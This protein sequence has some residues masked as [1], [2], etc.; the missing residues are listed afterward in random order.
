[1]WSVATIIT[2]LYSFMLESNPTLGSVETTPLKKRQ[3][4]ASSLEYNVT[5]NKDFVKLFPEYV[6][7]YD[8]EKMLRQQQLNDAQQQGG[9]STKLSG[10]TPGAAL[11]V[12]DGEDLP[13]G[14]A[15]AVIVA[16]L[17][18]IVVLSRFLF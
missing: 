9:G 3:L 5:N 4:A 16:L 10:S 6:E 1:M 15:L 11:L 13:L 14:A 12:G 7:R 8:R 18:L 17:S 2:G